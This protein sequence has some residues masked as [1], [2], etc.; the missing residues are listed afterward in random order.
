M[1]IPARAVAVLIIVLTIAG[2][3][4]PLLAP[5]AFAG[6]GPPGARTA[7]S[8][9]ASPPGPDG[10]PLPAPLGVAE[11]ILV[12]AGTGAVLWQQDDTLA[13]AP[14]SLTKLATAMVVLQRGNLAATATVTPDAAAVGGS[15]TRAPA[16]TVMTIEDMLWGLLL[17][18]GN[19]MAVALAHALSPD[20]T[21]G[22]F[23]RLMNADAAAVGATGTS[24]VNPHGLDAPGHLST[25]RDLALMTMA[26]LRF[27]LFAQIVGTVDHTL[28]WDGQPH[29]L[30]NH[31]KLLVRFPGTVGVKTGYTGQAGWALDSEVTRD[32]TTLLAVVLGTK[33]PAGYADSEALYTWGFANLPA[34]RAR[35]TDRLTPGTLPAVQ[36]TPH[37]GAPRPVADAVR[38]VAA[39]HPFS[40]NGVL[41]ALLAA[42]FGAAAVLT[43]QPRPS[44]GRHG[45]GGAGR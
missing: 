6:G 28:T 22:G 26:D 40:L 35:S 9:A 17:V 34:L 7:P 29:L 1:T 18:S 21:V 15:E 23:V 20:G 32:G 33:S 13:R 37:P 12:D 25:A 43:R 38:P 8:P 5:P 30:T 14:A 11:G 42:S 19:D 2:A 45:W 3:A 4:V 41:L 39:H 44:A 10:N 24:F 36:P 27:P 16:G 31:N